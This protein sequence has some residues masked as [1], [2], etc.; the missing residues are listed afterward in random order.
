MIDVSSSCQRDAKERVSW[1]VDF[2]KP[3]QWKEV[4][5]KDKEE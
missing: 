5:G 2:E 4:G 3:G 1:N